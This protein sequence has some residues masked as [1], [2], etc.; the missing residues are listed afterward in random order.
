MLNGALTFS[1]TAPPLLEL[2]E[3]AWPGEGPSVPLIHGELNDGRP[4]SLFECRLWR[5][6]KTGY[7][8]A[9]TVVL[10]AHWSSVKDMRYHRL[11]AVFAHLDSWLPPSQI[12][13][14]GSLPDSDEAFPLLRGEKTE[15]TIWRRHMDSYSF[16]QGMRID[17][18]EHVSVLFETERDE[19]FETFVA[20]VG[21]IQ[22]FF[23]F[24]F[25]DA[26]YPVRLIG[27]SSSHQT[28][29][30]DGHEPH[31]M[32]LTIW[33]TVFGAEYADHRR[34]PPLGPVLPMTAVAEQMQETLTRWMGLDRMARALFQRTLMLPDLPP[35]S[36]L[37]LRIGAL[38]RL[39]DDPLPSRDRLRITKA[40]KKTS[41]PKRLRRAT[42]ASLRSPFGVRLDTAIAGMPNIPFVPS[43]IGDGFGSR[44]E[45]SIANPGEELDDLVWNLGLV[46]YHVVLERLGCDERTRADV[47]GRLNDRRRGGIRP[48][49]DSARGARA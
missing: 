3:P 33:T 43:A 26:L 38:E 37:Y 16:E 2:D 35:E 34:G 47:L 41:L 7:G 6:G 29:S 18:A 11:Y 27:Y 46:Y 12:P 36:R 5:E 31:A 17:G 24:C 42:V 19:P 40:L 9:G 30:H 15:A 14:G 44:I 32:P 48:R 21:A 8:T 23:C 20:D 22:S 1:C 13:P 4:C 25:G 39:L 28:Q 49:R 10:G 45:R